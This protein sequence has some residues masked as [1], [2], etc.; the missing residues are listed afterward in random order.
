MKLK[1]E[2]EIK[3]F[4]CGSRYLNLIDADKFYDKN[5]SEIGKKTIYKC[6]ECGLIFGYYYF[7]VENNV[8]IFEVSALQ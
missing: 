8:F 6:S 2:K 3:C 1:F 5:W 7:E 4:R